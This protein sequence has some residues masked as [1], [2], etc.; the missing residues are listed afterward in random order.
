MDALVLRGRILS[1]P[2]ASALGPRSA[3]TLQRKYLVIEKVY[4]DTILDSEYYNYDFIG[5][6]QYTSK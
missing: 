1:L 3:L 5:L 4:P 2:N 6:K